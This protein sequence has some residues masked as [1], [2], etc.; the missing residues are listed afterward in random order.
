MRNKKAIILSI[1]LIAGAFTAYTH[2][3]LINSD[4]VSGFEAMN[5]YAWTGKHNTTLAYVKGVPVLREY[6]LTW[7]SP[8]Q[9]L[10]PELLTRVLHLPLGVAI[11]LL[12][13]ICLVLG[14]TGF[15]LV[16]DKYGFSRL[17]N[18]LSIGLILFSGPVLQRYYTYQ[19]GESLNFIIFPWIILM[20]PLFSR[21]YL[22]FLLPGA[23]VVISFFC[24]LQLL[25]IVPPL[26]FAL[27]ATNLQRFDPF[28]RGE[29]SWRAIKIKDVVVFLPCAISIVAALAL[30]YWGFVGKG[31]T[32]ANALRHASLSPLSFLV[33]MA[34]PLTSLSLGGSGY[35][36]LNS[37]PGMQQ[38]YLSA[39]SAAMLLTVVFLMK[40]LRNDDE[41]RAKYK[42]LTLFLFGFSVIVFTFLYARGSDIDY[43]TRHFKLSSFLLYPV[44]IDWFLRRKN[45]KVIAGV[46][47]VLMLY[48]VANHLRLA[49]NWLSHTAVTPS[50]YRLFPNVDMPLA[51]K[52]KLDSAIKE[53]TVVVSGYESRYA[54]DNALILPVFREAGDTTRIDGAGHQV[55]YLDTSGIGH[56]SN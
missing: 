43:S 38:V 53:K 20:G 6:F 40:D 4:S 14:A 11:T 17:A 36:F 7:W 28:F 25:I 29:A 1:I 54:I 49:K 51:V 27:I 41:R 46:C 32:P 10:G 13:F 2:T 52:L 19:G 44:M 33:P 37:R 31:V 12:N 56:L 47:G 24:K 42:L 5:G 34:S 50:G 15:F 3:Q 48:A 35:D 16:F 22:N 23:V 18:Y 30:T 39:L 21:K 45:G 26:I 55:L 8:G 9:Y